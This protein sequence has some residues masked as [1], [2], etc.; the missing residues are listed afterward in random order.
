MV[1]IWTVRCS[2]CKV[3]SAQ[4]PPSGD[5]PEVAELDVTF[6]RFSAEPEPADT[7]LPHTIE[8]QM[9]ANRTVTSRLRKLLLFCI[10]VLVT[11]SGNV[12]CDRQ[13]RRIFEL[14]AF[15]L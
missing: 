4:F 1:P 14:L 2:S 5:F 6:M 11:V 10:R 13:C 7:E 15:A 3:Y 9:Y 12:A 8:Y